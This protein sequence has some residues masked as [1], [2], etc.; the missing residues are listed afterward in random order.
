MIGVTQPSEVLTL[1]EEVD[2]V[3]LDVMSTGVALAWATEAFE[4]GLISERETGIHLEFGNSTGYIKAIQQLANRSNEFY[5]IL[6]KGTKRAAERYGGEDFACVLGQEMAGYATGE[7]FFVSQAYGFRHS[8]LDSAG[9]AYDQRATE[10]TVEEAVNYLLEEEEQRTALTC[11]VSCLFAR[12][13]YRMDRLQEA[14]RTVGLHT[15]SDRLSA[16]AGNVQ[17]ERWQLKFDTGYDPSQ[18]TIPKRC[19][20][21]VTQKGPIDETFLAAIAQAYRDAILKLTDRNN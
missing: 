3:G 14:L 2:K 6:G 9:Y 12:N 16:A 11:M 10:K 15:A 1:L 20:A 17:K 18:I 4:Q 8:H 13:I 21:V 7:V 5:S 19:K